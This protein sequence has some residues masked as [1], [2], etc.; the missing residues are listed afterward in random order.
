MEKEA[1]WIVSLSSQMM[2]PKEGKKKKSVFLLQDFS[3]MLCAKPQ[4]YTKI[5]KTFFQSAKK[6]TWQKYFYKT[7][8]CH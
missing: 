4:W 5:N 3:V 7:F 8:L 6:L 1:N 2:T